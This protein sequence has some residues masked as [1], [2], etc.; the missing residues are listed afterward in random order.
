M[1]TLKMIKEENTGSGRQKGAGGIMGL[2]TM[3]IFF[4]LLAVPCSLLTG[5]D[6]H[7]RP[8][9]FV[10]IPMGDGNVTEDGNERY[11]LGGGA[12]FGFEID[13]A[14]VWPNP[15]G[16]GYTLGIEAGMLINVLQSEE[17]FNVS[18]YSAGGVLVLYFFPLSRLF[19]RIDGAV[20]VYASAS[21]ELGSDPGLYFRAGGEAGFRFTPGF[22]LAANAGWKQFMQGESVRNSGVYAGLTG[23]MTIHTGSGIA[24][25]VNAT[26]D[27]YGE[28]FP[29]FMQLYQTNPIGNVVI[30]NTEN[31]EIRNVRLFFRAAGYTASEFPCGTVSI[32]PRGRSAEIP[33]YADFSPEVLQF[34]DT[35]RIV[36]ELVIRYSFLGQERE[37]VRAVTVA[38]H[39]RN[40]ITEGDASVLAA[41]VSPTSPETLDFARFIAG[42]SRSNSRTGHNANMLYAVW[43]LE[44]LRASGIKLGETYSNDDEV[45]FP[46]ETLAFSSGSS[47]D[48]AL[49]FAASLESVAVPSAFI[50]TD[51]D[52][53]VALSLGIGAASAESLFNGTDRILIINDEVWLPLSMSSYN[54]GFMACWTQAV[55]ILN[56]AFSEGRQVDFVIVQDAWV[57]YP[58]APLP[59]LG[60]T[61]IRTDD[62]AALREVNRIIQAYITQEINPLIGRQTG[63]NTAAGLNRLGILLAR[64]GRIAEAKTAYERAAGMGSLP[65]MNNRGNLALTEQDFAAAE[66]WFR[67]VLQRESQNRSALRG[68][69][70]VSGSR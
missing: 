59:E 36:G 2:R 27:Q 55:R 70:R 12:D 45:Q 8:K 39:N 48:L 1:T 65:A 46:A 23:Q 44:G 68:L 60:R 67:Q 69:E 33:L 58:P 6:F 50:K 53:L 16:L 49:L 34:T 19:T 51:D 31:A 4:A 24:R 25:G 41:F 43:L 52:F 61:I 66:R 29:V 5:L 40:K 20:G 47:R 54:D 18:Y 63:I 14:T 57:S 15:L 35:G 7:F 37:T 32:I 21:E 62:E 26:L 56:Q 17:V 9:G 28:L 13:L 11:S 22:T 38:V 42:L 64:A 30:R 3:I 10:S